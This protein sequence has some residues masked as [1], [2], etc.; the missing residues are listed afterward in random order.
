MGI[1]Q[2]LPAQL[3]GTPTGEALACGAGILTALPE[4]EEG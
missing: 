3:I 4:G 1:K 2:P